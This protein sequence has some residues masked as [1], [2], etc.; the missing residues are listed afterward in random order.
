MPI[1]VMYLSHSALVTNFVTLA[2]SNCPG[3]QAIGGTGFYTAHVQ[4]ISINSHGLIITS[5]SVFFHSHMNSNTKIN[6]TWTQLYRL[7]WQTMRRQFHSHIHFTTRRGSQAIRFRYSESALWTEE[8]P[9]TYLFFSSSLT[10]TS[11]WPPLITKVS[12][13]W[14]WVHLA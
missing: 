8:S 9:E 2:H 4:N 6:P 12:L 1:I 13:H 11:L 7:F 3:Q 10:R 14:V 5:M